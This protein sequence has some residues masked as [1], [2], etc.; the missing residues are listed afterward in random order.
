MRQWRRR[1]RRGSRPAVSLVV[2]GLVAVAAFSG[3]AAGQP[4]SVYTIRAGG[5]LDWQPPGGGV[6]QTSVSDP[7]STSGTFSDSLGSAD[8]S[9]AAGPGIARG[10]IAGSFFSPALNTFRFNP[11]AAADSTTELTIGGAGS[12]N[13]SLNLH[14]DSTIK[15]DAC[16]FSCGI[17][18]AVHGPGGL[19]QINVQQ[20]LVQNGLGLTADPINGGYHLHGDVATPQFNVSA[21]A[22]IALTIG[23]QITVNN[24][25]GGAGGTSIFRGDATVSFASTGPVLN[26]PSGYTVS[27]PGVVGNRWTD[28]FV[29]PEPTTARLSVNPSQP[30]CGQQVAF[31]GSASTAA[32]GAQLFK[33]RWDFDD[34]SGLLVTDEA[35]TQHTYAGFG[36][37]HPTL[38]VQDDQGNPSTPDQATVAERDNGVPTAVI[39]APSTIANG[40]TVSF[41]GS[42]SSDPEAACG[43]HLVNWIWQIDSNS[44]V[45]TSTPTVSSSAFAGQLG[46]GVHTLSLT[47]QDDSGNDSAPASQ[48]LTVTGGRPTARLS[49]NPSQPTCGQQVAF[50]GSASTAAAGAQLFKYRWDFDDGSGLLVTDEATTQHTYAGFGV[51]HPTLV[52]QDDQGN[53]STPDQATVAERDNGVP[54]AVISAPSTIAN[55]QTVSF[56]GS[57]SSDPEAACGSHLVNWIWQIDSNSPVQ[58]STPTVSSSAFAGQLGPGVHTLSLTVQDD[59]GNDSAPASQQLTVTGGRPTARLSVNPSQPTCG[60]QVAFDGSASTAAAGAQLFKYRWDFDDGSGLLV[61]DEATTQ[62]TYA[63]FGVYHPTLVVQ[64]DQGNPSTPDQATVAERDNGVPTAVISAPSTIANGQ[65]VSFDGSGS[66]DPEAACGSHLVN[67]IWQIDS[68][69]PVQTSTPTVSSSAFAGQLGPGVHTL[70]LTVEDDS[71]NKSAAASQQL[72]LRGP[73]EFTAS[74][75][76]MPQSGQLTVQSTDP[77]PGYDQVVFFLATQGASGSFQPNN[78]SVAADGSWGGTLTLVEGPPPGSYEI[79]ARC[80][81]LTG[82][83]NPIDYAPVPITI[84]RGT[85][86]A[87]RTS[88]PQSGQLTVQS[89]DPCPGYANV[90]VFFT[91]APQGIFQ[92]QHSLDPDGSWGDTLTLVEGPPPGSYHLGARCISHPGGPNPIDYAP[93]PI[94]ITRGTFTAS[95]T[96]MP[97]SGQLTVQS[98]DPCPGYDQVV[99]FLATQGA[100]GSFQPN[101][102]SVA[103]DGSWGGT[104]TLVEGPPPGSYEIGARCISLIRQSP[105]RSTTRRFRSRSPAARSPP[106]APRCLRAGS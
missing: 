98:T 48:Q 27:G 31:D 62:H 86:T 41:D 11:N 93:V 83:L 46:P 88:M 63:G 13:T 22:T 80:I 21:P 71:G 7:V 1:G 91:D 6:S 96:S 106:R 59:S 44:P 50:D 15:L 39:S 18:V 14:V 40:Q 45:Q 81:R 38:V 60:Q 52:V 54:T 77:C 82:S 16:P 42:G 79:G 10:S 19:S 43:S 69:S 75:T 70:S 51:Y 76:S 3:A 61:T 34:G 49:V 37:Y 74:R 20:G 2:L 94:T 92:Q 102:L 73:P 35:T 12:F 36:V 29:P 103:A 89:T 87:S 95:R 8:Y 101:N 25:G 4:G 56:D 24:L 28:P 68:N 85:F 90:N 104:L 58:T 67:W 53:P 26:V 97:Q 30:T 84:T 32:A 17:T 66:S 47:V 57:G 100:S 105:T 72:T 33:Y 23:V 5:D 9:V 65:T 99:F 55:G 64:D 78:L